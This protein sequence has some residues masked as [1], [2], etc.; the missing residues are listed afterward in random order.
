MLH[1][2]LTTALITELDPGWKS[3]YESQST[4]DSASYT[5]TTQNAGHGLVRRA[6]RA[7]SKGEGGDTRD[8]DRTPSFDK[9]RHNRQVRMQQL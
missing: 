7:R 5:E 2:G 6:S 9:H 8:A 3:Q 4:M 1:P